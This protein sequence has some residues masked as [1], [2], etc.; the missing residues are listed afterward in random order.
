MLHA[1]IDGRSHDVS[2]RELEVTPVMGDAEIKGR[3]A[4]F[5]DI[6][7]DRLDGYVVDRSPSGDVIVRPEAV[8]G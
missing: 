2:R 7:L 4:Q 3:L 8:Y 6:G 1:R 5:L